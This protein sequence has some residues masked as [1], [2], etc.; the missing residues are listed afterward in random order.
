MNTLFIGNADELA[1]VTV[2]VDFYRK[3][4]EGTI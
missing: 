2:L 4:F 3:P 1:D